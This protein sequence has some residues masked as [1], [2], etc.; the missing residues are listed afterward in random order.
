MRLVRK[1]GVG[2][3]REEACH[4]LLP[5]SS[6]E[7]PRAWHESLTAFTDL[8]TEAPPSNVHAREGD[9]G[10]LVAARSVPKQLWR[11]ER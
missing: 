1:D 3:E 4:V 10:D 6:E 5:E 8:R 11:N 7:H 9:T 2:Q